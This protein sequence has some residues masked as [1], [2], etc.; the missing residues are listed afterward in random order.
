MSVFYKPYM[1]KYNL[2]VMFFTVMLV[3]SMA[4]AADT[5]Y[6]LFDKQKKTIVLDPGHGGYDKGA[7]GPDGTLEKT[8]TLNL[9]R[10]IA[11]ELA[12]N[13]RVVLTRTGDYWLDIP[14]RTASANHVEADL[15]ISIHTGGSFLHQA[16][17]I[18]L[19][20]F[21]EFAEPSIASDTDP[22]QPFKSINDQVPWP[23]IHNRHQ[24]SSKVLAQLMLNRINK[25]R[26]FTKSDI[27][28]AQF[29]ILEG[30]DMPAVC[31]EIGYITNPAEEKSLRDISVL[32]NIAKGIRNGIDDFFEK[33]R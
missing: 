28:D 31:L 12:N 15:F 17:G 5:K 3:C 32:S 13:Y 8:V 29:M 27:Q 11:K 7:Q 14:A 21:K 16:S 10:M 18:T 20:Y 6:P 23:N 24:K 9:A 25:Q 26:I 1:I 22:S 2:V 19:Y 33:D 30:A 4:T